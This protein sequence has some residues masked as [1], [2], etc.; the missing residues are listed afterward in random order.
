[1]PLNHNV[2]IKITKYLFHILGSDEYDAGSLGRFNAN[3]GNNEKIAE[4]KQLLFCNK[5]EQNEI[6]YSTKKF[7]ILAKRK[8]I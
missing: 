2:P 5:N 8:H 3:T 6:N 1:M 4:R 7:I